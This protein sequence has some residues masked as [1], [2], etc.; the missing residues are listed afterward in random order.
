M[1]EGV[2]INC[3]ICRASID[4]KTGYF[5]CNQD[6]D[7]DHCLNCEQSKKFNAGYD[8]KEELKLLEEI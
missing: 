7:W 6:C 1:H 4:Y 8:S 5:T 2:A 3:D